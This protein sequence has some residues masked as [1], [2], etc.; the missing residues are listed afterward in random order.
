MNIKN[1]GNKKWNL[2]KMYFIV[3][4]ILKYSTNEQCKMMS[5][6]YSKLLVVDN[7]LQFYCWNVETFCMQKKK[8]GRHIIGNLSKTMHIFSLL[9]KVVW[10][11]NLSCIFIDIVIILWIFY[12]LWHFRNT[13]SSCLFY[14]LLLLYLCLTLTWVLVVNEEFWVL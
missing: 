13:N 14:L 6:L 8:N 1:V 11:H 5:N 3:W 4:S 7:F 2:G 10:I 12:V 9:K